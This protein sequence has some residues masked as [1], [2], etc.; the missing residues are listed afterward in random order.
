MNGNRSKG[1]W[2][3]VA[4]VA[5][6]F[7][8]IARVQSGVEN[9]RAYADPVIKFFAA[10]SQAD[11]DA[12]VRAHHTNSL[13]RTGAY[14]VDLSPLVVFVGLV[15]PLTLQSSPTGVGL[16]RTSA[17]PLLSEFLQRPPPHSLA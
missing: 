5:I 1:A 9:A 15:A 4:M 17:A 13:S 2:I 11:S 8:S 3:W 14:G 6:S 12:S 16:M 7:A 10:G